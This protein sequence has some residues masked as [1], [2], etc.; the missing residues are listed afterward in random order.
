MDTLHD[1]VLAVWVVSKYLLLFLFLWG[2]YF[3]L[4][5]MLFYIEGWF[6]PGRDSAM[7]SL[8]GDQIDNNS[9]RARQTGEL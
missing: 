8:A 3:Q 5:F 4:L 1:V 9:W 7:Y 6:N 2:M